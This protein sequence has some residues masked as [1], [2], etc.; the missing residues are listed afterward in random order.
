[1]AGEAR[2]RG[3]DGVVCGHIRRA[4][5]RRIGGTLYCNDGD[6]VDSQSALLEHRDGRLELR[7][8]PP[9][10]EWRG[11]HTASRVTA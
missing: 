6:W 4:Q 11:A 3:H 8:W 7:Q 2:R 10:P 5:M 9:A 1:M